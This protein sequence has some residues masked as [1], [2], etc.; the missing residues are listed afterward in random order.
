[1]HYKGDFSGAFY[2]AGVS[3]VDYGMCMYRYGFAHGGVIA[4]CGTF[5]V[6]SDYMKPAIHMASFDASAG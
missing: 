3:R 1:M 4:A 6:F 2:H 5:F